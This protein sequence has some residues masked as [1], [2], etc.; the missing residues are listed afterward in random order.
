M[1]HIWEWLLVWM[2]GLG[3]YPN[4]PSIYF[5]GRL[6]MS[7]VKVLSLRLKMLIPMEHKLL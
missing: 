5:E 1:E 3:R 7:L 4:S 2:Q 6:D